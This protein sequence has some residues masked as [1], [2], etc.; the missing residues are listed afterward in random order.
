MVLVLWFLWLYCCTCRVIN[1]RVSQSDSCK[2]VVIVQTVLLLYC[3]IILMSVLSDINELES[4]HSGQ[5][6]NCA[7]IVVTA[8]LLQSVRH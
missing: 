8:I 6:Q 3:L 1:S 2:T 4:Q 7:H 5:L